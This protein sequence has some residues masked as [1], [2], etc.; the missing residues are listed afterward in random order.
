MFAVGDAAV[1]GFMC[2][3]YFASTVAPGKQ[4]ITSISWSKSALE[5]NN[6]VSVESIT[7]P[8]RVYEA[9]DW[10][11]DKLINETFVVNP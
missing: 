1:N 4:Y 9:D 5:E 8:I 11:S 6:I 2:D 3:P 10:M 7:L